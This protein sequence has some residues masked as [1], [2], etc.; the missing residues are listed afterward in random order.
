MTLNVKHGI[1][2]DQFLVLLVLDCF[3]TFSAV[4]KW[5][6][7]VLLPGTCMA[8]AKR[9]AMLEYDYLVPVVLYLRTTLL[10]Y[11]LCQLFIIHEIA[12]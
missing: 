8:K 9:K 12:I 3:V 5:R 6:S 1:V 11:F 10:Q 2:D 4:R 7:T